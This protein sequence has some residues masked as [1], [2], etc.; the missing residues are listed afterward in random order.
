MRLLLLRMLLLLRQVHGSRG[1]SSPLLLLWLLLLEL[2]LQ[3]DLLLLLL[4][5]QAY[6][7][8]LD[9]LRLLLLLLKL[10]WWWLLR[11]AHWYWIRI[12]TCHDPSH[13]HA[14]IPRRH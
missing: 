5:R 1:R 2:M 7:S 12:S 14:T 6:M 11:H 4:L 9:Y 10:L 3:L 8:Y 13:L